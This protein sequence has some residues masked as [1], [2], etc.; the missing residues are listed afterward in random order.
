MLPLQRVELLA[1]PLIP[2]LQLVLVGLVVQKLDLGDLLDALLDENG[3]GFY[4]VLA[5]RED[6]LDLRNVKILYRLQKGV[7]ASP[8]R[9]QTLLRRP[10]VRVHLLLRI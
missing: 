5:V 1:Q 4:K 6:F 3:R 10:S 2:V 8:K 7:E 9:H